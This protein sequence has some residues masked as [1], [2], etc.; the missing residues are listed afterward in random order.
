MNKS[1]ILVNLFFVS[2]FLNADDREK[3]FA[4]A[5]KASFESLNSDLLVQSLREESKALEQK[6]ENASKT[7]AQLTAARD[8]DVNALVEQKEAL[9]TQNE[10]LKTRLEKV[11]EEQKTLQEQYKK[12]E[13]EY[14]K[15]SQELLALVEAHST[16]A[17]NNLKVREYR[18]Q[19][20]N[21]LTERYEQALQDLE[22][23]RNLILE[24]QK[25]LQT[26]VEA[27]S[28][29]FVGTNLYSMAHENKESNKGKDVA[30][31]DEISKTKDIKETKKE[32]K[33]SKKS[34]D[35]K[36]SSDEK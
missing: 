23:A 12:A 26:I 17:A 3:P 10:D 19:D 16:L 20:V 36:G 21:A 24:N 18:D 15:A 27:V 1:K 22:A 29:A 5:A 28:V 30:K 6:L 11:L 8:A 14:K 32:S 13:A 33:S 34:K 4:D 9:E 7:Q 35:S 25:D 31:E 2:F